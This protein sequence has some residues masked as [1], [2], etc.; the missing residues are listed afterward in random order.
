MSTNPTPTKSAAKWSLIVTTLLLLAITY[1]L[2][3]T[4]NQ[5]GRGAADDLIYHWPTIQ[6][7]AQQLPTPDLSNYQS[8]TTPAYHLELAVLHR[9]GLPRTAIQLYANLWTVLLLGLLAYRAGKSFGKPGL[10]I[11]LPLLTSMYVLFPAIWLLPDNAGWLAVLLILILALDY[12]YSTKTALTAGIVL[13]FLV[14]IR[15]VHIWAAAILWITAWIGTNQQTPTLTP[16]KLFSDPITRTRRLILALIATIPATLFLLYFLR[17]WGGLVPPAF[18]DRHQG[19]NLATPAFILTQITILSIFFTPLLLPQLK[20]IL[21]S[22][23][24]WIIAALTTGLILA[25]IPQSTY[26]VEAG[27]YSGWWNIINKL[28]TIADRSPIILLGAPAGA[29][30]CIIWAS[31]ITRRDTWIF[32]TTLAAFTAAQTANHASWQ[33]YHEP[34]LLILIILILTRAPLAIQHPKRTILG[35][36]ALAALLAAITIPTLLNAKPAIMPMP[37]TN[38]SS[39]S[40]PSSP[41]FYS[42]PPL[43]PLPP[44]SH[45]SSLSH[46]DG[47][48]PG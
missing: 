45:S 12:P 34:L 43:P 35:S 38:S 1:P 42:P 28:P 29:L 41:S 24:T 19:P 17:L 23:R 14:L 7:F 27:R 47:R 8:A 30:A 9:I 20:T 6:T 25:I 44:S 15:Q 22:H 11:T 40:S 4:N 39:P 21:K 31:L 5:S 16:T 32:A 48:G 37:T 33:R 26:S 18:Q 2:I 46:S 13:A 10:L 36:A 3:L